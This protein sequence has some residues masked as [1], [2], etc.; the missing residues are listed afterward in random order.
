MDR[1]RK[2]LI[3]RFQG[4][5]K[6]ISNLKQKLN[7]VNEQ[8]ESWFQ[9]KEVM[10]KQIFDLISHIKGVKSQKDDFNIQL[11]ELRQQ[12]DNYNAKVK[13]LISKIKE[14][15]KQKRDAF[16][17]YGIKVDPSRLKDRI[18]KLEGSIET[19]AFSFKKEKKVME[20]IKQ[21]KKKY[22]ESSKLVSVL[23]AVDKVSKDIDGA[24][25]KAQEFHKKIQQYVKGNQA[26]YKEFIDISKHI[27]DFKDKQQKA[28]Q[29]F[30]DFKTE[31]NGVNDKLKEKLFEAKELEDKLNKHRNN[32][33]L[34]RKQ[35]E[36]VILKD[37]QE[38]VEGK[39]KRG[40]K[41]TTD[42]LLVFQ[43]GEEN[44]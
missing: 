34:K 27:D 28:F 38:K 35:N 25:K 44:K 43:K 5:K 16:K 18:E 22:E 7:F 20:E 33:E 39:L 10:K 19:E 31:F 3:K 8:K 21:L 41:L 24:K 26:G 6:E 30:L 15:N 13:E 12:R 42:D 1:Y 23:D 2:E 17:K 32:I 14:L 37:K 11:R 29:C 9:K 4:L 40:E 36:D